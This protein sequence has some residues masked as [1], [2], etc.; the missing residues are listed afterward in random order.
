MDTNSCVFDPVERRLEDAV[1]L[2]E[3]AQAAYFLPDDFR[4]NLQACIQAFRSV[5]W[6]LQ[7][8]KGK[9]QGF[10][11]WYAAWQQKMRHDSILRWLVEA[12]NKIEKQGD[13]E[14]RSTL[15]LTFF[16][17]WADAPFVEKQ[18]PPKTRPD[19]LG[20]Y[21][22]SLL[23][24]EKMADEALLKVERRWVDSEMPEFEILEAL[25]H[26]YGELSKIVFDAH[27]RLMEQRDAY[28]AFAHKLET[29]N[30][31]LPD[32]MLSASSPR[33]AWI[34]LKKGDSMSMHTRQETFSISESIP[35]VE[36]RYGNVEAAM[37]ALNN[38]K[39]FREKCLIWFCRAKRYLE[40]DGY[41]IPTA[42]LWTERRAHVFQLVMLDRADKHIVM[43]D[44]ADTARRLKA[45]SVM[46]INEAW[47]A[48][49][50]FLS[51]GKHAM[52][53]PNREEALVLDG[54]TCEGRSVGC[55][56]HFERQATE[57]LFGAEHVEEGHLPNILTPFLTLWNIKRQK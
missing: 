53:Y 49:A 46:L 20:R 5:S 42:L 24:K 30:F 4:L 37:E 3:R 17:G 12:R 43:R 50:S 39:D 32:S 44:L 34:K 47:V 25:C 26:C 48:P 29:T 36:Q 55:F 45:V 1:A 6:V 31:E 56:A 41:A 23:P 11:P 27:Q 16:S 35:L 7:N 21:M 33:V 19:Q 14:T 57:I 28:C 18:L 51:T 2:W 40:V 52:D 38:T 13:L 9:I 15:K 54:L 10:D 22:A 8:Q